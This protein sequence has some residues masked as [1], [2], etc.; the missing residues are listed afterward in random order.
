VAHTCSMP[1]PRVTEGR[2]L[3]F[4]VNGVA[5]CGEVSCACGSLQLLHPCQS[6]GSTFQMTVTIFAAERLAAVQEVWKL[7]DA[8]VELAGCHA[9]L[10]VP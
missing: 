5:R 2:F 8:A 7:L 6:S 4:G 3:L 1:S 10:C 9:L